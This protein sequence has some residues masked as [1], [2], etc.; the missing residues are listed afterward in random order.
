MISS[1]FRPD[2]QKN[3]NFSVKYEVKIVHS[4]SSSDLKPY[5]DSFLTLPVPPY[6]LLGLFKAT[7][8][9]LWIGALSLCTPSWAVAD[10]SHP[11][12][13]LYAAIAQH[14][15][16]DQYQ[17]N[18]QAHRLL[19]QHY[20]DQY[21]YDSAI[22]HLDEAAKLALQGGDR[23]SLVELLNEQGRLY[24]WADQY[25][26]A[27]HVLLRAKDLAAQVAP[28]H[29]QASNLAYL[30]EVYIAMGNYQQAL[31]YQL[32]GLKMSTDLADSAGMGMAYHQLGSIYWYREQ[33]EPAREYLVKALKMY[34]PG[35]HAVNRYTILA[36]L[37]S[38]YSQQ[39]M[40][41]AAK[42]YAK[43]SLALAEATG[44]GYG[45][46]FSTGML[47]TIDQQEGDHAAAIPRLQAV[48]KQMQHMGLRAEVIDY[49]IVLSTSLLAVGKVDEAI[50]MLR[51]LL[52]EADSLGS[53]RLK[54]EANQAMAQALEAKGDI[55][56]AYV[57]FKRHSL[58]RDSLLNEKT[59]EQMATLETEYR[60]QQQQERITELEAQEQRQLGRLQFYGFLSGLFVLT[61]GLW[62]L[63]RR[64][65]AQGQQVKVL[66]QQQLGLQH[67]HDQLAQHHAE[68]QGITQALTR[69][70]HVPLSEMR[71]EVGD[72]AG[73]QQEKVQQLIQRMEQQVAGLSVYAPSSRGQA[74]RELIDLKELLP[75]VIA[76]LP[77][78]LRQQAP[79]I[80]LDDLPKVQGERQ[81]VE[82]LF[83]HLISNAIKFRADGELSIFLKV[84]REGDA[85]VFMLQDNGKG[86]SMSQKE[87]LTQFLSLATNDLG[88]AGVGLVVARHIVSNHG[89]RIWLE[90]T[91]G[92]GTTVYFSLPSKNT[93]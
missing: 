33:Y 7:I 70:L 58:Y 44:Y 86:I 49:S 13:S 43:E 35:T 53:K 93:H 72:V 21:Q 40:Y 48:I 55:D 25:T 9:F 34:A 54:S 28:V 29:V 47:G 41:Q 80:Q 77:E 4:W 76:S 10:Q 32:R 92:Q 38:I 8:R 50:P 45:Q 37:A 17:A 16:H 15:A 61:L 62:V 30:T 85:F 75:K 60:I 31:A 2:I 23:Q 88:S 1:K 78:A 11:M 14:Q 59:L 84:Y 82:L 18:W 66:H 71:A 46:A 6:P 90:S 89:G 51:N 36:S 24:F 67:R 20:R 19:A 73:P 3:P 68:L 56:A 91:P 79:R 12:D 74:R 83:H 26:D 22:S 42:Q 64:Y 27:L 57:Y 69:G 39:A 81:Q 52:A 87:Q 5:H 63:Y 65:R